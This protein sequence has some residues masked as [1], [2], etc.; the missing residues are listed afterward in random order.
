MMKNI[1]KLFLTIAILIPFSGAAQAESLTCFQRR[2]FLEMKF[3]RDEAGNMSVSLNNPEGIN[4]LPLFQG[5][6]SPAQLPLLQFQADDLKNWPTFVKLTWSK[7][8]CSQSAED[9]WR[10]QCNGKAESKKAWPYQTN[11]F[12]AYTHEQK[13][14]ETKYDS[15]EFSWEVTTDM[16]TYFLGF[17]FAADSCIAN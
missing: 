12:F 10:F 7:D 3:I 17:K 5:V 2:P 15:R 16:A 6:V 8:Q 14:V 11:T 9:P 13:G 4:G 1:T